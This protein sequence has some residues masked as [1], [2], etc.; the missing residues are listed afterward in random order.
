MHPG[1][2]RLPG[3]QRVSEEVDH[4][5][6]KLGRGNRARRAPYDVLRADGVIL[7]GRAISDG[8]FA[9]EIREVAE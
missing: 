2:R 4:V 8:P 9:S 3:C 7:L 5:L 1:S 6:G